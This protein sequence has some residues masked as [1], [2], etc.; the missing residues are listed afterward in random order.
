[1]RRYSQTRYIIAP[2]PLCA[3]PVSGFGGPWDEGS[4][5]QHG[6]TLGGRAGGLATPSSH[7][8]A[9]SPTLLTLS[10]PKSHHP[11]KAKHPSFPC[12][13]PFQHNLHNGEAARSHPVALQCSRAP[14]KESRWRS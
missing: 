3:G 13:H 1:M 14:G 5:V 2:C 10:F 6:S 8:R 4:G 7:S 11:T 9:L 12:W